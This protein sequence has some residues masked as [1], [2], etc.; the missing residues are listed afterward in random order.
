MEWV[1]CYLITHSEIGPN[2]YRE[3]RPYR[4]YIQ[5]EVSQDAALINFYEA[6]TSKKIDMKFNS[7]EQLVNLSECTYEK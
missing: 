6:F 3:Y 5:K 2:D 1:I 4:G 7:P